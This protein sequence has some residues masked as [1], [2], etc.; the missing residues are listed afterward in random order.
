MRF[1]LLGEK[2][3]LFRIPRVIVLLASLT[4]CYRRY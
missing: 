1:E 4:S 2:M 3:A